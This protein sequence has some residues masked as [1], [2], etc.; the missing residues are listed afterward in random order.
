MTYPIG[1]W[2][3]NAD[4]RPWLRDNNYLALF[5]FL[6]QY[7]PRS[8]LIQD[9]LALAVRIKEQFPDMV[10]IHRDYSHHE[11]D[12]WQKRTESQF[13][14][15]WVQQGHPE[16]VR[17]LTNEP[18][19]GRDTAAA[20][21]RHEARTIQ[22]AHEEGI[23]HFGQPFRVVAFNESVG[24]FEKDWLPLMNE[25][26]HAVIKYNAFIGYHGY[27]NVSLPAAFMPIEWLSD[28]VT[29]DMSLRSRLQPDWARP[30]LTPSKDKG[31]WYLLRE[32]WVIAHF[33]ELGYTQEQLTDI[34]IE[35]EFGY[36][37]IKGGN[38]YVNAVIDTL[39]LEYGEQRFNFDMRGITSYQQLHVAYFPDMSYFER[40]AK[41]FAWWIDIVDNAFWKHSS[42]LY[43]INQDWHLPEAHDISV[44]EMRPLFPEMIK[45]SQAYHNQTTPEPAPTPQPE[46][47]QEPVRG[48]DYEMIPQ[49]ISTRGDGTTLRNSRS[50]ISEETIELFPPETIETLVSETCM[51]RRGLSLAQGL[52]EW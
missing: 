41:E 22:L 50:L 24:G 38:D 39:R 30:D 21:A 25:L 44:G 33:M 40:I 16:I 52:T 32:I 26:W 15:R 34:H 49:I 51:V 13:V 43:S 14:G 48:V 35:T 10:V 5:T 8:I 9:G 31:Y 19:F 46:P 42:L 18:G 3:D 12:E 23:R 6:E 2:I 1:L 36:D 29:E 27:M 4:L 11:G 17:Y 45:L 7:K 28:P 20:F 37:N 47:I